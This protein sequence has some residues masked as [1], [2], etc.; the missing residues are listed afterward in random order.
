MQ[1]MVYA[2]SLCEAGNAVKTRLQ[3][4]QWYVIEAILESTEYI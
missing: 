4:I 1:A 2:A 3:M